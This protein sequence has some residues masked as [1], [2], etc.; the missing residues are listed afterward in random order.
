MKPVC[1]AA[2]TH[3]ALVVI[4][5]FICKWMCLI[6]GTRMSCN[7]VPSK[8]DVMGWN[9]QSLADYMR[10]VSINEQQYKCFHMFNN[11]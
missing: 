6:K 7:N 11:S 2:A 3:E 8:V 10:K 5:A 9:Q 1:E 4:K